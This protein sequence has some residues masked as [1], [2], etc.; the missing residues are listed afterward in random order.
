MELITHSLGGKYEPFWLI[1]SSCKPRHQKHS[2]I[3]VLQC[4]TAVNFQV[5]LWCFKQGIQQKRLMFWHVPYQ[6]ALYRERR[7]LC[8]T[9]SAERCQEL[10]LNSLRDQSLQERS[11]H[12]TNI[13]QTLQTLQK[14]GASPGSL[15]SPRRSQRWVQDSPSPTGN[16]LPVD[17]AYSTHLR[18]HSGAVTR[19]QPSAATQ[20]LLQLCLQTRKKAN[21]KSK[22]VVGP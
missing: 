15:T 19:C 8:P 12:C 7:M 9:A 5:I 11:L 20:P 14:H 6:T 22:A 16:L 18:C 21:F 3:P 17:V 1:I 4:S 2:Y 10:W 13:A